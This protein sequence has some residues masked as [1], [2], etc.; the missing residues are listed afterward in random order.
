MA[1]SE[2]GPQ[3]QQDG[4]KVQRLVDFLNDPALGLQVVVNDPGA[5]VAYILFP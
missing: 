4:E 5:G 1:S 3:N 2:K